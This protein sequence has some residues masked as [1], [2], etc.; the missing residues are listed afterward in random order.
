MGPNFMELKGSI[1]C[2]QEPAH[3]YSSFFLDPLSPSEG[4]W[5]Q[6]AEENILDPRVMKQWEV[7]KIT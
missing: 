3:T 7:K 6:G 2:S 5:E 1:P 4:V